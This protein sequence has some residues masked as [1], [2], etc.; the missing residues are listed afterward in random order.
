MIIL[1][2][3]ETYLS[4]FKLSFHPNFHVYLTSLENHNEVVQRQQLN[5]QPISRNGL[6]D[7]Q[8]A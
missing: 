6:I 1:P 8:E 3:L 2:S 5:F 7:N 4:Y